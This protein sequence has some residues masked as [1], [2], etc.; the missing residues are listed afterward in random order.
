M[1]VDGLCAPGYDLRALFPDHMDLDG[2]AEFNNVVVRGELDGAFGT[3]GTIH[4]G[5]LNNL[6]TDPTAGIR[7]DSAIAKPGTWTHYVD[8]AA[9]GAAPFIQHPNFTLRADGAVIGKMIRLPWTSFVPETHNSAWTYWTYYV[10]PGAANTTLF[11][12]ASVVL[13]LGVVITGVRMKGWRSGGGSDV[14][15]VR[16]VRVDENGVNATVATL[17]HTGSGWQVVA[18]AV[19]AENHDG[20][21]TYALELEMKGVSSAVNARLQYAELDYQMAN[22]EQTI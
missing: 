3:F 20:T 6:P 10:Q 22:Y 4:A 11:M 1:T 12:R 17:T 14:C 18:S 19:L 5:R 16:L 9:T 13:P 8:L 21:F 15:I 7:L 2:T